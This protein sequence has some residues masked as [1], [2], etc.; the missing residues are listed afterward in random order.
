MQL[1]WRDMTKEEAE[2]VE[3]VWPTD[4]VSVWV[5]R[6]ASAEYCQGILGECA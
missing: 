6:F 3:F 5:L 2:V 1:D 4:G